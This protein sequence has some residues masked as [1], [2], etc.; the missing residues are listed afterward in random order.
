MSHIAR[1][2][3]WTQTAHKLLRESISRAKVEEMLLSQNDI[4]HLRST[5]LRPELSALLIYNVGSMRA[6]LIY[7]QQLYSKI[8]NQM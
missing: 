3:T 6:L 5:L 1:A 8:N 2:V 4:V 7:L